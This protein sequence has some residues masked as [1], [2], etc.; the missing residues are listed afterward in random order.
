METELVPT[1]LTLT[2]ILGVIVGRFLTLLRAGFRKK[3][4]EDRMTEIVDRL[5][6]MV[7]DQRAGLTLLDGNPIGG[8]VLLQRI[9]FELEALGTQAARVRTEIQ[10]GR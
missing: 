10:K 9:E 5:A 1:Y 8:R 4:G 3:P 7:D 6:R 2:F